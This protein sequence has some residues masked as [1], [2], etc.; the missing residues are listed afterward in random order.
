M[1][2]SIKD[3]DSLKAVNTK[4]MNDYKATIVTEQDKKLYSQLNDYLGKWR[5]ARDK[6]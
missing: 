5:D 1:D 2:N 3:I 4:I 6:S